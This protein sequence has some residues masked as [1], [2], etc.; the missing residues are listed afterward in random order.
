MGKAARANPRS[1]DLSPTITMTREHAITRGIAVTCLQ[2][3][4]RGFFGRLKWLLVGR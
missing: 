1:L 3:L 4:Q 2:V